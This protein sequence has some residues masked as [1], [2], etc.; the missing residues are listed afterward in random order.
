MKNI[1]IYI[2]FVLGALVF[3]CSEDDKLTVVIQETAER[4]AVL[5]TVSSE[6]TAWNALDTAETLTLVL[7]EQ[8]IED[9]ALLGEVRVYV[10]LIDNTDDA[11]TTTQETLIS[12][13][14]ASEFAGDVNG[15]PRTTYSVSL[16]EV[17]AVLGIVL[18][19]YNCGDQ[20][21]FR[22][23]LDLTDGR[24]ITDTDVTGTVS[25]GSFFSSP[26]N[27]RVSLIAL[28]PSDDLYTGQYQLTTTSN[29]I[30]G[31]ADYADGVYTIESISNTI[32]VLRAVTTFPAF[33]GFGPVDVQFEFICGEIILTP[34][35]SVGAGCS[36]AIT[37]G[38][39]NVNATYDQVNPD[40]SDFTINFTS[41]EAD[42]CGQ[43]T[44]QAAI[45]LTKL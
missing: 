28:L 22:L 42:D 33:G 29:G 1:K 30:F 16:A 31:V 6:G 8:D 44:A 38:P 32:K 3:S 5:R 10:N 34:G 21:N 9:G 11:T 27:Y 36:A 2:L 39:A 18:G 12:T 41:D 45:R 24:T 19:D 20:F 43:G 14:P 7:E 15:L 26:F 23:E 4:G 17:E 25:G 13:I 35:Q 37:S 40:D